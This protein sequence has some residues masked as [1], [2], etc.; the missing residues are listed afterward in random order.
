MTSNKTQWAV[1]VGKINEATLDQFAS[2]IFAAHWNTVFLYLLPISSESGEAHCWS[3]FGAQDRGW[4]SFGDPLMLA[5]HLF[6]PHEFAALLT[7]LWCCKSILHA[8]PYYGRHKDGSL[9][10]YLHLSPQN[11]WACY[12][13]DKGELRWQELSSFLINCP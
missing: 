1:Q 10:K 9:P 8:Q 3:S 6:M 4:A 5:L 2:L 12:M 7:P 13:T 11:L